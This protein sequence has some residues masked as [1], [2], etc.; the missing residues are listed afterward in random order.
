[1][2]SLLTVGRRKIPFVL[3]PYPIFKDATGRQLLLI[4][5]DKVDLANSKIVSDGVDHI[6]GP[7]GRRRSLPA[8]S[9]TWVIGWRNNG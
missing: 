8:P 5:R 1:M 7:V 4:G 9:K 3:M 6:K 2:I